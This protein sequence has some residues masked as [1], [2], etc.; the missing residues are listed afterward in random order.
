MLYTAIMAIEMHNGF[1]ITRVTEGNTSRHIISVN[2]T[3]SQRVL[4]LFK[5]KNMVVPY[6]MRTFDAIVPSDFLAYALASSCIDHGE[7]SLEVILC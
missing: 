6:C 1:H 3:Q 2:I 5:V 7:T 4:C